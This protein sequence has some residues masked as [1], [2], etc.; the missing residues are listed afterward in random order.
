MGLYSEIEILMAGAPDE[1]R[2]THHWNVPQDKAESRAGAEFLPMMIC[3]PLLV[4]HG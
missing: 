2:W 3:Q 4:L 1:T